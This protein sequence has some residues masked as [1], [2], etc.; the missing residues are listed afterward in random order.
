MTTKVSSIAKVLQI[1]E[2]IYM[3]IKHQNHILGVQKQ[4]HHMRYHAR[5]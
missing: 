1:L 2:A 5:L 3:Y 4:E